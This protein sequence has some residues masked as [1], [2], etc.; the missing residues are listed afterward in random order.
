MQL[1]VRVQGS[2]PALVLLHGFTGSAA[3][4]DGMFADRYTTWAVELPGHGGS[5]RAAR[6]LWQTAADVLETVAAPAF[7]LLG[8]SLGARVALHVALQAP[9]RV[10]ALVLEGANPGIEGDAE[11]QARR[12]ADEELA[13]LLETE[14]IT[15]FVDRWE[16]LPLW[17]SQ[18]RVDPARRRALRAQRLRNDP[19]GLA[20]SLRSTGLATQEDLAGRLREITCPTLLLTGGLDRRYTELAIRMAARMPAATAATIPGAGHAAHFEDPAAFTAVVS[21][22]LSKQEGDDRR[23]R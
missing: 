6:N 4:W 23:W 11:R 8:Y 20:D 13:R 17:A 5:P 19:A 12:A 2:G 1:N 7:A 16:R 3:T 15:A 21:A 18:E 22:F 14:G 9:R 10:R